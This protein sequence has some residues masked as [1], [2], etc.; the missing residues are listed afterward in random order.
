MR[1][2]CRLCALCWMSWALSSHAA[3]FNGIDNSLASLYRTSAA[4]S[5]SVSPENLTGEAG[6]GAAATE[7]LQKQL[8]R[9]LGRG[10]K[11][12]PAVAVKAGETLTLADVQGPGAIEHIWFTPTGN[13]RTSILRIYWD[14]ETEPSVEVPVGDFFGMGLGKYA[15]IN[16]LAVAVNPGSG[17]NS[18]WV[19]PFR[20]KFRMTLENIG[21]SEVLLFYQIDYVLTDVTKDAGYFHAQFRRTNPVKEKE[22]Y[23]I[24]DDVIGQGQYV[25]TYMTWGPNHAGWW[26]EGEIKFYLDGDRDFPTIAGTGT[27]DYFCGSYDFVNQTTQQYEEFSHAYSGMPQVIRAEDRDVHPKFGLYRW[28]I[29]DPIRFKEKLRVT[30]QDLGWKNE[31]GP[32]PEYLAAQDDISSVAF[33]YQTEPHKKFPPL[34]SKAELEVE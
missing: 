9:N 29:T 30:I 26:G 2:M 18:Y 19:M 27:E 13:W 17:F 1:W 33:W 7:G 21:T 16:S 5:R 28:H 3:P 24:V 14:S 4:K 31:N 32:D 34:P 12:N 11:I 23:T 25:G 8:A 15:P 22:V 10:W 6:K 20:K